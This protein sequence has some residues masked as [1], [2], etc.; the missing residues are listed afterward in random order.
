SI[1]Q[2]KQFERL[3]IQPKRESGT[4]LDN[5]AVEIDGR[6]D[7]GEWVY[8]KDGNKDTRGTLQMKT[9]EVEASEGST[10]KL[11]V[12]DIQRMTYREIPDKQRK[13]RKPMVY[14]DS[15]RIRVGIRNEG[16]SGFRIEMVSFEG[17]LNKRAKSH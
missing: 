11:T 13:N 2:L 17:N 4:F 9:V 10:L 15:R 12:T 7:L 1:D 14:G 8:G 3:A 16:D 5:R 6:I